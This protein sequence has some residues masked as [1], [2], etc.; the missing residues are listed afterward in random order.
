MKF[1]S[2]SNGYIKYL[3]GLCNKV[4]NNVGAGYTKEKPYI[5]VV[6][7]IGHHRFL[8]P[9]T[10]YKSTQDKIASSQCSAFKLHA[11][12]DPNDKLGMISI[13]Y[14]IPIL[15]SEVALLDIASQD[16]KYQNLLH[17]QLEF[18]KQNEEEITSR[19]VK[20]YD[21]VVNKRS[22]FFVKISTDVPTLI[23]LY[24][25]FKA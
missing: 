3:Q 9:L 14:M 23:A 15:D 19:A 5:G 13:N 10:S 6:L 17:K 11:R 2:V 18:I 25:E 16:T 20:L 1:Y 4:P 7:E 24:R 8:A 12:Q 22:Q 21:H